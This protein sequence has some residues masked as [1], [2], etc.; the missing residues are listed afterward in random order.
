MNIGSLRYYPDR[1]TCLA[2]YV[3]CQWDFVEIIEESIDEEVVDSRQLLFL[4][5]NP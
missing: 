3:I 1:M 5:A 2:Q 4:C